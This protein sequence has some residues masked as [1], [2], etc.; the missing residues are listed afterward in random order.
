[1]RTIERSSFKKDPSETIKIVKGSNFFVFRGKV[2]LSLPSFRPVYNAHERV[3]LP[4]SHKNSAS[5]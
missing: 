2:E 3:T 5:R 1:M 4:W